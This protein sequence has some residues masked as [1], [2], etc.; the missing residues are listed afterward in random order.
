MTTQR[1]KPLLKLRIQGPGVRPGAIN[2]PDL[3]R[4]CRA[5]QDA[6]SRQ[7]EAMRGG[8]SLRPGPKTSVVSEECTLELT[9]IEKGST[10]LPFTLAKPQQP[11]LMPDM[12]NFGHDVVRQVAMAVKIL[13]SRK[14]LKNENFEAGLLDSLRDMG[15]ILN[16][17]LMKI[18]WIVPSN[19]KP[20]VRA[21]FDKRVKERVIERIK[22]PTTR[23]ETVEGVLEMADFKSQ[24]H[25]CRIHPSVGQSIVCTFTTLQEQGI[26]EALRKPVRIMGTATINPNS[27]KV[28]SIDIRKI[29]IIEELLIGEKDFHLG[30]TI[31][32]L[33]EAQGVEPLRNPRVLVG[34]W[35]EVEDIDLF[36]EDIYSSRGA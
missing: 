21:M 32:Q 6:V 14:S 2:V 8:Q 22:A 4:I 11:L 20:T 26:L 34:G 28:E 16:K 7:A 12:T 5:T 36:L 33:A 23:S 27:G 18:E 25:R 1:I 9:G 24:D 35:P 19:G 15:E 3:I 17:N 29:E 31:E 10:V 13:G 30:R